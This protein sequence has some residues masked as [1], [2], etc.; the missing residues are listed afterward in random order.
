MI[1]YFIRS[2]N[3]GVLSEFIVVGAIPGEASTRNI[4]AVHSGCGIKISA[5][6]PTT[7]LI[8]ESQKEVMAQ[9][10]NCEP[11]TV[12][13]LLGTAAMNADANGVEVKYIE[14]LSILSIE[15]CDLKKDEADKAK[16]FALS[17]TEADVSSFTFPTSIDVYSSSL[18]VSIVDLGVHVGV[19]LASGG[20]H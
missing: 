7:F 6:E 1:T 2:E 10:M 9:V 15:E 8:T 5:M 4:L 20:K 12:D 13:E 14:S 3:V 17:E 11:F 16:L 18:K 19:S